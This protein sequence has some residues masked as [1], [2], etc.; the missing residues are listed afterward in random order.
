MKGLLVKNEV[1]F[2]NKLRRI[3]QPAQLKEAGFI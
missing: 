3:I 2:V 1:I